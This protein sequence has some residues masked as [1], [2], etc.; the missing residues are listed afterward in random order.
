MPLLL[1]R[2]RDLL[3]RV[4]LYLS[5]VAIASAQLMPLR[6]GF[7]ILQLVQSNG[8][9][10]SQREISEAQSRGFFTAGLES[11]IAS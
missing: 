7:K 6:L 2:R 5:C 10:I 9:T 1:Q 4:M 3:F 8:A 11:R